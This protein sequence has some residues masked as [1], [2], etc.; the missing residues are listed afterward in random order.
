MANLTSNFTVIDSVTHSPVSGANVFANGVGV[1]STNSLGQ[2][3]VSQPSGSTYTLSITA[4]GYVNMSQLGVAAGSVLPPILIEAAGMT[5][6]IIFTLNVSPDSA[7]VNQLFTFS[8]GGSTVSTNYTAGG[9]MVP[10]LSPTVTQNVTASITGYNAVSQTFPAGATSGTIELTASTDAG[11]QQPTVGVATQDPN[12]STILPTPYQAPSPE[13]IAPNIVQGKYFTMT[14]AR[15]YIGNLFI[16][17]L[18]SIQFALQDNQIPIYGYASRDFDALAQGKA[19]VQGQLTINFISE[20]YLYTALNAYTDFVGQPPVPPN[21]TTAQQQQ[22]MNT[23]VAGLTSPALTDNTAAIT[24]AKQEVLNLAAT[25]NGQALLKNA[26]ALQSQLNDNQ[27][28]DLLGLAG[29]DYPNAVYQNIPFDIVINFQGAGRTV[30]RRLESCTLI[31]NETVLDHNGSPILDS[32][33]FIARRL[34]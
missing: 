22:R 9:V 32:Y 26:K 25:P 10:N 29:G 24:A 6:G 23:L 33:G 16:D 8:N 15:M 1:G 20:G 27:Q 34:R 3:S 18:N 5:S 17:E 31:S 28:N 21:N 14:Q 4:T 13:F 2:I 19:L 30:T 12:T 11:M 7:A